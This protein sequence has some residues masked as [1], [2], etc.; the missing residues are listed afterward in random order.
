MIA[1]HGITSPLV[2][3]QGYRSAPRSFS[4]GAIVSTGLAKLDMAQ[5]RDLSRQ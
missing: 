5:A 1:I 2:V 3:R 4:N